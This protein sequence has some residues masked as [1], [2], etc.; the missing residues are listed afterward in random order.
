MARPFNG[1]GHPVLE[2]I[3]CVFLCN[4]E[5]IEP[6]PA[7]GSQNTLSLSKSKVF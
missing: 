7:A 1:R 5:I 3:Y 4:G 6:I 2:A